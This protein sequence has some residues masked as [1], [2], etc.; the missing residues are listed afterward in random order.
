MI[1]ETIAHYRITAK[2]GEVVWA[3]CTG[4]STQSSIARSPSKSNSPRCLWVLQQLLRARN[5][6]RF[7]R[8]VQD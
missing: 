1:G 8:Q 3:R 5:P 2:I 6:E 7:P 4:L